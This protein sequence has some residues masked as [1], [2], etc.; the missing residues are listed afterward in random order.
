MLILPFLY[1]CDLVCVDVSVLE[2]GRC[3]KLG[4]AAQ[5]VEAGVHITVHLLHPS[6][7]IINHSALH[8][9]YLSFLSLHLHITSLCHPP[10][11]LHLYLHHPSSTLLS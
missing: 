5:N 9:L 4:H 3:E 8:S 7:F 11:I 6:S 1:R 2:P 10:S